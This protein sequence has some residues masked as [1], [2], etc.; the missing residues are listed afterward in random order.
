MTFT[1]LGNDMKKAGKKRINRRRNYFIK[2]DFQ[3]KYIFT[4][5]LSMIVGTLFFA[6]LL[7]MLS[8]DSM[9]IAYDEYGLHIAKTPLLLFSNIF[10]IHWLLM[11]AVALIIIALSMRLAHRV[12]GPMYRFEMFLDK[13]IGGDFRGDL[14]LRGKDEGR[15]IAA[16]LN[17]LNDMLSW[18]LGRCRE[19]AKEIE[20]G[21]ADLMGEGGV[22]GGDPR[23]EVGTE[24]LADVA[25]LSSQLCEAMQ[26]FKLKTDA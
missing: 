21:L 18:R 19:L 24:T 1:I 6:L 3:G 13:M 8:M 16:R 23:N 10:G 12:A 4:H 22:E 26:H 14:R 7:T 5:F 2:K 9:S 20:V 15:D 25:Q 11:V 17:D